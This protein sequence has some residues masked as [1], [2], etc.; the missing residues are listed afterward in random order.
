MCL[1]GW[2]LLL[3]LARRRK[4]VLSCVV[5]CLVVGCGL[6]VSFLLSCF[7]GDVTWTHSQVYGNT[8]LKTECNYEDGNNPAQWLKAYT[9]AQLTLGRRTFQGT[10]S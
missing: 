3:C 7:F 4:W 2:H 5:Q 10:I 1:V 9:I 6:V 8:P